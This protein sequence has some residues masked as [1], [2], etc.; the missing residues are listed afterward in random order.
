MNEQKKPMTCAE[1]GR[2]GQ[3][4]FRK[5]HSKKQLKKWSDMGVKA[6]AEARRKK[7]NVD[8]SKKTLNPAKK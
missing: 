4:A 8:K 1:A 3:A 5:N 2:K 6:M 7:A